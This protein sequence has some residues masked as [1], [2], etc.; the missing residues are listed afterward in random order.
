MKL[1]V[2]ALSFVWFAGATPDILIYIYIYIDSL[3]RW[4][5]G[6]RLPRSSCSDLGNEGVS[7]PVSHRKRQSQTLFP[8]AKG[9]TPYLPKSPLAKIPLAQPIIFERCRT[10]GTGAWNWVFGH[11][12]R[13]FDQSHRA[14]ANLVP[15]SVPQQDTR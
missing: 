5:K 2:L 8:T 14:F 9:K 7:D 12:S 10:N 15:G 1:F 13:I 4:E 6:L 3:L 11:L